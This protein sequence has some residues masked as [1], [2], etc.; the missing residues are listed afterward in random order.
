MLSTNSQHCLMLHV[1]SVCTPCCMFLDV[2][3]CCC[4]KF[5]TGQLPTFLFFRDRRSVAQQCWIHLHSSSNIVGATKLITHG[6]QRL[7][8]CILPTMHCRS[9]QCWELLH[10]LA[11]H[12]Q[13]GRNNSQ[14]CWRNNG[15]SYCVLL[16]AALGLQSREHLLKVLVTRVLVPV[17]SDSAVQLM[18]RA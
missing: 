11:H 9:Q 14:H 6:L 12:C 5:E 8:G 3:A 15:G 17:L 13:H 2:V 10:P 1:A 18:W 16:H 7:M 4:A